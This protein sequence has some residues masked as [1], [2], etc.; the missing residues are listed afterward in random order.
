LDASQRRRFIAE[1]ADDAENARGKRENVGCFIAERIAR[2]RTRQLAFP[3]KV[4]VFR[5]FR[6]DL[7]R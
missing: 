3:R 1:Y 5:V 4:C 7:R 6:D 2:S